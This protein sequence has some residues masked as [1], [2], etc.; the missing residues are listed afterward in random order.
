MKS[1]LITGSGLVVTL[2]GYRPGTRQAEHR[3]LRSRLSLVLRGGFREDARK[4]AATLGAGDVL[5]KSRTVRHADDF[6][7]DGALLLSVE[8]EG[9]RLSRLAEDC[10]RSR[11]DAASLR[12]GAALVEGALARDAQAVDAACADL[13]TSDDDSARAEPP[14]WLTQLREEIETSGLAQVDV[15]QQA[16]KAGVH[17]AHVSR[18]FRR[19]FGVSLTEHARVHGVRRALTL[20]LRPGAALSE[21]ALAAGFYDQ[22]HM[23]RAFRSVSG[24][25]PG[26]LRRLFAHAAAAG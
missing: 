17:P 19:C 2:S 11:G 13:I 7:E 3:D 24:R 14:S 16:R 6:G 25:S 12:L 4:G 20:M 23:N 15:A 26:A 18:L 22:S 5:L 8:F 21:A 9:E 1:T 10:W